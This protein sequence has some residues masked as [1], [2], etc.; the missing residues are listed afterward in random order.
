M[1]KPHLIYWSE[2]TLETAWLA[3]WCYEHEV[4]GSQCV[5][6]V[7]FDKWDLSSTLS[8]LS[9]LIRFFISRGSVGTS[10]VDSN[11][12]CKKQLLVFLYFPLIKLFKASINL[13]IWNC[14]SLKKDDVIQHITHIHQS[15]DLLLSCDVGNQEE[16]SEKKNSSAS[17]NTTQTLLQQLTMFQSLQNHFWSPGFN[18]GTKRDS[19]IWS[20]VCDMTLSLIFSV[21]LTRGG[22]CTRLAQRTDP[23]QEG[24]NP[25]S[26]RA[27]KTLT[28]TL[29]NSTQLPALLRAMFSFSPSIPT[30]TSVS[31][32]LRP[33]VRILQDC[34]VGGKF[35]ATRLTGVRLF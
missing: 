24:R 26:L 6:E 7:C 18:T 22:V 4:K 9:P 13:D 5:A 25:P 33:P 29:W 14:T 10:H 11:K 16:N 34:D 12:C 28:L 35:R 27:E 1:Q 17:G 15:T 3:F 31:A 21:F 2:M 32:N 30:S 8:S 20:S 19:L 23:K